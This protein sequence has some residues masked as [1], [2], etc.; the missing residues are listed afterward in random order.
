MW[1]DMYFYI[2]AVIVYPILAIAL[3]VVFYAV[4]RRFIW[5]SIAVAVVL[6]LICYLPE[7]LYYESRG[8]FIVFTLMQLALMVIVILLLKL[9]DKKKRGE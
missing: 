6:D 4:R 5:W 9:V 8:L 7:F 2:P 1:S 3:P